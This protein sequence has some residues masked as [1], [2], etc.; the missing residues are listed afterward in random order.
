MLVAAGR[1]QARRYEISTGRRKRGQSV[2]HATLKGPAT[3]RGSSISNEGVR[4]TSQ[5]VLKNPAYA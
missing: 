4:I 3:L 5:V 1:D 2:N